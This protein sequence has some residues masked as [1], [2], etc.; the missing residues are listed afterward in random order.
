MQRTGYSGLYDI[1]AYSTLIDEF[2]GVTDEPSEEPSNKPSEEPSKEPT[3]E[4][5]DKPSAD[6]PV[7]LSV[8]S[9]QQ[10]PVSPSENNTPAT[11]DNN[12]AVVFALITVIAAGTVI[13]LT[14]VSRKKERS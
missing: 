7:Q 14:I 1:A 13:S 3:N 5:S 6:K 11:G 8:T 12:M 9:S 2:Y 4:P 10:F